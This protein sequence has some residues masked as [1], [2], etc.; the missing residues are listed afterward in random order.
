M[1]ACVSNKKEY[2][3]NN[4]PN[5]ENNNNLIKM[6]LTKKDIQSNDSC[7]PSSSHN[8]DSQRLS[9]HSNISST[10]ESAAPQQQQR[11][12]HNEAKQHNTP[13][14]VSH[15]NKAKKHNN[16]FSKLTEQDE[17]PLS[18][19]EQLFTFDNPFN[20]ST[21][22]NNYYFNFNHKNLTFSTI[23]NYNHI[24]TSNISDKHITAYKL[25]QLN[26]RSWYKEKIALSHKF[27][28]E[29]DNSSNEQLN[30]HSHL[31]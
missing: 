14:N 4:R 9:K 12:K 20:I 21:Y 8:I 29:R 10:N 2:S 18:P 3:K 31:Y 25:L 5:N 1:G 22:L 28:K 16:T 23:D 13:N 15:S 27:T 7:V 19:I 11:H 17:Q 26:E 30:L 6:S 24:I